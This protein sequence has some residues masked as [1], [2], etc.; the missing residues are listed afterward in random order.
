[1]LDG[2]MR[3]LLLLG[4]AF[5]ALPTHAAAQPRLLD[6]GRFVVY[7]GDRVVGTEEFTIELHTDSLVLFSESKRTARQGP[8]EVPVVQ[9]FQVILR[10]IDYELRDYI[11]EL[12][13]MGMSEKRG[14]VPADTTI[15]AFREDS[16][17]GGGFTY[18]RPPGRFFVLEQ[19]GFALFDLMGRNLTRLTF[20]EREVPLLVLGPADT[21]TTGKVKRVGKETIRWGQAKVAADHLR[22]TDRDAVFDL[23]MHPQG[24][25][26]RLTSPTLGVR[27]EREPPQAKSAAGS[28]G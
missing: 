16:R 14:V 13:A 1:M 10:E 3:I 9:R 27:V 11:S 8:S 21:L 6:A 12:S 18:E 28:G 20:T 24:H 15:T 4:A 26:V 22:I 25:M 19:G 17:A 7:A 23:W 2:F 5:L